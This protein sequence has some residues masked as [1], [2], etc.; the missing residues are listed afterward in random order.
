MWMPGILLAQGSP[1]AAPNQVE[2]E[3]FLETRNAL[4]PHE[5]VT[6]SSF[7]HHLGFSTAADCEPVCLLH[8]WWAGGCTSKW[9]AYMM[10]C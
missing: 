5:A 7:L 10:L 6:V 9:C 4:H 8:G 2:R 3:L 1:L